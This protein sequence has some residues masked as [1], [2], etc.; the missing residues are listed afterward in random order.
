MLP[1][2]A[3]Q[4]AEVVVSLILII[5]LILFLGWVIKHF[6]IM[7]QQNCQDIKV[8]G[9]VLISQRERLIFVEARGEELLLGVT[10]SSINL[11]HKFTKS[12]NDN[13]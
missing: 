5:A 12:D 1:F 4:V 3:G 13:T 9:K 10:A 11:L 2:E 8:K 6:K 7:P